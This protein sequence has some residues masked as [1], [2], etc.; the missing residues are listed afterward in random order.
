MM[1]S[2]EVFLQGIPLRVCLAAMGA[3]NHKVGIILMKIPEVFQ[4]DSVA[5]APK[6]A[7]LA[8]KLHEDCFQRDCG[9]GGCHASEA[10]LS[11]SIIC[12]I[13]LDQIIFI[14]CMHVVMHAYIDCSDD[15]ITIV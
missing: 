2:V 14:C 5:I 1:T 4:Q 10:N 8:E 3:V 7:V 9:A 13:V 12:I 15:S 6:L 11:S